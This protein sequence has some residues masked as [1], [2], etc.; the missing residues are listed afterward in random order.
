M[1]TMSEDKGSL[2]A[3]TLDDKVYAI[4]G[5]GPGLQL[6]T[7]EMLDPNINTWMGCKSLRSARLAFCR[8]QYFCQANMQYA[9]LCLLMLFMAVIELQ[10]RL[11]VVF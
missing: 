6:N 1:A 5:G 10:C 3:V 4:G 8:A 2:A 9:C 7:V 11:K